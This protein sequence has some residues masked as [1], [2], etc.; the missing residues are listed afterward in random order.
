MRIGTRT[1]RSV[2]RT[3]ASSPCYR[4]ASHPASDIRAAF[5]LIEVMFAVVVFCT[6]MF[7]ILALVANSLAGARRL[8]QPMVD[9]GEV[10]S[11]LSQTVGK[12]NLVEGN[13]FHLNL[14]Q[15]LGDKYD[16]YECTYNVQ[17]VQSN[18]LFEVDF[19]IHDDRNPSVSKPVVSKMSILLYSPKS[20][21]GS[22]DGGTSNP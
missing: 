10:A 21:A 15:L 12:T 13:D 22:L 20:Q 14:G 19:F 11:W 4:A 5:T 18:K 6:A 3:R 2:R 8:Q 1:T 17:E 7:V 16:G 9:A